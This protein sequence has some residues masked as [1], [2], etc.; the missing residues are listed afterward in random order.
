VSDSSE[1]TSRVKK[2]AG[3]LA[4]LI[5]V[6]AA[7]V[8]VLFQVD[9]RLA[10]CLGGTGATF[11]GAL[12]LPHYS[13]L[14]YLMD[15]NNPRASKGKV[16]AGV[17]GAEVRFSY[18]ADDLRGE[19]LTLRAT[20]VTVGPSG[21]INRVAPASDNLTFPSLPAPRE[22]SQG[23]GNVAFVDIISSNPR[24]RYRVVLELYLG[25]GF[26]DRL[27]LAETSAFQE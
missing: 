6:A 10:P 12:V 26:T 23:A 1:E 9:P 16:Y 14:T 2:V 25:D 15:S 21:T 8:G 17:F 13:Y 18:H 4:G 11:T 27:A 5:A 22:C 20:L 24:Q 3:A 19:S 7:T